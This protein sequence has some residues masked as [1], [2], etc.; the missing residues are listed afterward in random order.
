[1]FL[2]I[3]NTCKEMVPVDLDNHS[4]ESSFGINEMVSSILRTAIAVVTEVIGQG[5]RTVCI[6]LLYSL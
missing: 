3:E 2:C 1:M 6:L 4:F 5:M